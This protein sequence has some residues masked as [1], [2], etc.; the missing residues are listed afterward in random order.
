MKNLDGKISQ[1]EI[2]ELKSII[3]SLS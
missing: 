2:M 1:E 3:E